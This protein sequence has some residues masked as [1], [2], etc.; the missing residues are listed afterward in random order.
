[1]NHEL[2]FQAHTIVAVGDLN[3]AI[4]QPAWQQFSA[5]ERGIDAVQ[6][7]SERA[8]KGLYCKSL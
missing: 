6:V 5:S 8:N 7:I 4:F 3:P 2:V 1:M